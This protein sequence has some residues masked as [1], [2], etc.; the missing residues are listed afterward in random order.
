MP[1]F[2]TFIEDGK[3]IVA[4][5]HRL[6]GPRSK[7]LMLQLRK[8]R[9]DKIILAGMASKLCVEARMREFLE[10]G[11]EVAIVRDAA[12]GPRTPEGDGYASALVNLRY[13]AN[14]LRTT[15]QTV[16]ELQAGK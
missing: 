13:I 12:A 8:Q 11:F 7:D 16:Q 3:T 6:Y 10:R 9:V 5:P 2:K 14:A 1:E 4:S 15:D